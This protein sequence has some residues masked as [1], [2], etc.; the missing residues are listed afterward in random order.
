[1][2]IHINSHLYIIV[3]A[4]LN[5]TESEKDTRKPTTQ[6]KKWGVINTVGVLVTLTVLVKFLVPSLQLL[7]ILM[8]LVCGCCSLKFYPLCHLFYHS[9]YGFP[10]V[11]P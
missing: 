8:F 3:Y 9:L 6:L 1:M 7:A 10:H 11:H 4:Q 2:L 5:E